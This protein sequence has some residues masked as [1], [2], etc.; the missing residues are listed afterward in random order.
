MATILI[1]D[2]AGLFVALETTPIVRSGCRLIPIHSTKEL[3]AKAS[4]V[5]PDVIVLDAEMLG[6][7]LKQALRALKSDRK[8]RSV[9]VVIATRDP[10]AMQG[11]V[12]DR[13]VVFK[14]PFPPDEVGATLRRL[15]PVA[16]RISVRVPVSLPVV[17]QIGGK[18]ITLRTKDLGR[19]GL[20]LK[21]PKDLPRG[22]RFTASFVLPDEA[23]GG[24]A[25]R[26]ISVE[27]EV[28]RR[29]EP[30]EID[31]IAGVGAVF[32]ELGTA[33]AGHLERFV[34]SAAA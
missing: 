11:L 4:T 27:C 16:R 31:R 24:G 25:S 17:C 32:V 29:V 1:A 30:D 5:S 13:D 20:F 3:L 22:T 18:R 33:D 21:T 9:P 7:G 28:V 19:G 23:P 15:L 12:S 26:P 34:A 10:E 6:S 2:E 14:K 8:L